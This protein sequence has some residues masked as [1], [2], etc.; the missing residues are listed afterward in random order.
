MK[1][2]GSKSWLLVFVVVM[3][4]IFVARETQKRH[5]YVEHM[6]ADRL[7]NDSEKSEVL[8]YYESII[9]DKPVDVTKLSN[10]AKVVINTITDNP[11]T[12][13][14]DSVVSKLN[15]AGKSGP[16]AQPD[17]RKEQF[18]SLIIAQNL[19]I[20]Y[21]YQNIYKD[22]KSTPSRSEF[23]Q[24]LQTVISK[25]YFLQTLKTIQTIL[26]GKGGMTTFKPEDP[27]YKTFILQAF[28]EFYDPAVDLFGDTLLTTNLDKTVNVNLN[29]PLQKNLVDI[30]HAYYYPTT[31]FF[32]WLIRLIFG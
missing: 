30:A 19:G 28:K 17:M 13:V 24:Q 27:P 31:D 8:S 21:D 1:L 15:K 16:R 9:I 5:K 32:T 22:S 20:F 14:T 7:L 2:S 10:K 25:S 4:L 12:A 18:V 29:G 3:L 6:E 26:D 11:L 23:E